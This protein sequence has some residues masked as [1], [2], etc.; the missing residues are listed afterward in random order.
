MCIGSS[1]I[2][3]FA[4]TYDHQENHIRVFRNN[5]FYSLKQVR[6]N[7]FV[8]FEYG[9]S[10]VVLNEHGGRDGLTGSDFKWATNVNRCVYSHT[11]PHKIIFVELNSYSTSTALFYVNHKIS[12]NIFFRRSLSDV[13]M[14]KKQTRLFSRIF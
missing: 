3:H 1:T 12:R 13:V 11:F 7:T 5:D 8:N 10:T 2:I 9:T 14:M 6:Y 4:E